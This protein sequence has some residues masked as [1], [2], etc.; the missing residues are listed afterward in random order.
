MQA[1]QA[2]LPS[3]RVPTATSTVWKEECVYS[4]HSQ[5]DEGGILVDLNSWV[6]VSPKFAPLH[7]K[8]SGQATKVYLNIKRAVVPK[9]VSVTNFSCLTDK[10]RGSRFANPN[11]RSISLRCRNCWWVSRREN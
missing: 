11:R 6:S 3:V 1:L 2:A 7:F 8:L 5:D 4:F 9:K 10:G